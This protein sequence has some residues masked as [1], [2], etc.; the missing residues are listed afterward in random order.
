MGALPMLQLLPNGG[1]PRTR[2]LAATMVL[3]GSMLA[4]TG[5][6]AQTDPMPAGRCAVAT[7]ERVPFFDRERRTAWTSATLSRL[8]A[9]VEHSDAPAVCFEELMSGRVD[10]G[11]G[12]RWVPDNAL[13]LCA[14]T[15]DSRAR[16]DCFKAALA[17]GRDWSAAIR[18]CVADTTRVASANAPLEPATRPVPRKLEAC[19]A[20][21]DDCDGDGHASIARG[22]DDCD[23]QDPRR[24]PGNVEIANDRDE[25]CDPTTI[26]GRDGDRDGDG[27]IDARV[28]NPDFSPSARRGATICGTDCDDSQRWR[29]PGAAELPNGLDDDCD[30]EVDNLIGDWWS[31]GPSVPDWPY[32]R[33][34]RSR[35]RD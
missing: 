1:L 9:G 33:P 16:I 11:Q 28:C 12:T 29:H 10:W 27:F 19:V 31:P 15:V 35:S 24:Y 34:P 22:G 30:G 20:P 3:I 26:A 25:D 6:T 2:V 13:R 32:T 21:P 5:V 14:G 17:N 7:V 4:S 18:Q 23:D 8:C